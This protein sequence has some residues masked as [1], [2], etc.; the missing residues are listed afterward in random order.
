MD[1]M[2]VLLVF[3]T[4]PEV[5][6]M[7]PVV[8]ALQAD[9]AF[10]VEVCVTSQHRDM[11]DQML[12][13]FD[14]K[15]DYD[16]NVMRENQD[17]FYLTSQVLTCMKGVLEEAKPDIS[18]VQGDTTTVFAA[19]LA[20]FYLKIPVGHVEAGLRS[21]DVYSPFP[22]EMNRKL[23]GQIATYHF[24]PTKQS[25]ENLLQEGFSAQQVFVTGNTVIDALLWM[26][27]RID[28]QAV[29]QVLPEKV[30]SLT[31]SKQPYVLITGHRRESFGE[32]F[33]NICKAI[34]E[35]A[36]RHTD[37]Q[38]VY[39]VHLNPNVQSIV[40]EQLS[41][42][43]NV[44]LI[45]PVGYQSFVYLMDRSRIVLTDSG[46]VQEEAPSLGKP[47][48]VMREVTERAE[49]VAAGTAKLVGTNVETIVKEVDKLITLPDAYE[50]MAKAVNP[51][52]DGTSAQQIVS[53]LK[54]RAV[55]PVLDAKQGAAL[56]N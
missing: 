37:W 52:G 53:I 17:L 8:K 44:H 33:K 9:P 29:Q 43:S 5:I 47:V 7:A 27:E 31:E 18:L 6:K 36:R 49:G 54:E 23:A 51:Y 4:R 14:L 50:A 12:Q 56:I 15:A 34:A 13:L 35:L 26:R 25:A 10:T 46:G 48:L 2:K 16:L 42:F 32:G 11:Q 3:G 30:F 41:E 45:D 22:E 40:F 28:L 21:H 38:F 1:L 24:A 20:A 19:S 39:P 55:Q